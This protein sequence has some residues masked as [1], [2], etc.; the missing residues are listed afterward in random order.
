MNPSN[1]REGIRQGGQVL[2]KSATATLTAKEILN[3]GIIIADTADGAVALTVP[4]AAAAFKG[5][6]ILFGN[7]GAA[8]LTVVVAAGFGGGGG[9]DTTITLSIGDGAMLF[10]DG[11][12]WYNVNIAT[13]T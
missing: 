11:S 10:C 4:A 12:Y 1:A 7:K 13:A 2:V 9:G 3:Y 5:M 6:T 8:D